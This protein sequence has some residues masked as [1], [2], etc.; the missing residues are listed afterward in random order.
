M[1]KTPT[2][3]T[4]RMA[5]LVTK[6]SRFDISNPSATNLGSL[7]FVDQRYA[8]DGVL[9]PSWAKDG[10]R[11]VGYAKVKVEIMPTDSMLH[12][13]VA[14]LRAEREKIIADAQ[15]EATRIEGE[16][17]KLLAISFDGAEA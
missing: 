5:T 10:Y 12:G 9:D 15:A 11:L 8:P 6:H 1:S 13:A 7:S 3:I 17:Q 2:I 16:I 14:S 4:G